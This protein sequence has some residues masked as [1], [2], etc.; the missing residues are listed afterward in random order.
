MGSNPI[1]GTSER[2]SF[3]GKIVSS[4]FRI[5]AHEKASKDGLVVKDSSSKYVCNPACRCRGFKHA[6]Q[7]TGF[8]RLASLT[9][10]L[11]LRRRRPGRPPFRPESSLR[12]DSTQ[13]RQVT[14]NHL[15]RFD[16]L[17]AIC[18]NAIAF[19][20]DLCFFTF[21]SK[22]YE[23]I[24]LCDVERGNR[25]QARVPK[26]KESLLRRDRSGNTQRAV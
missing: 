19:R 26:S 12:G 24:E 18:C 8:V 10:S 4:V 20:G 3:I 17:L 14:L 9:R 13:L 23:R 21:R 6:G 25:R 5:V 2:Q 11:R 1:I 22:C 7:L 15:L 16:L